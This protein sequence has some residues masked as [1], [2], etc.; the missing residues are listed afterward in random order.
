MSLSFWQWWSNFRMEVP[1]TWFYI[2]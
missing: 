2:T 1:C